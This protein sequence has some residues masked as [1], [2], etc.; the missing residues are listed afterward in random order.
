M[1][2]RSDADR[3]TDRLVCCVGHVRTGGESVVQHTPD[4]ARCTR[5]NPGLDDADTKQDRKGFARETQPGPGR[6]RSDTPDAKQL[7]RADGPPCGVSLT[8]ETS[9]TPH[10]RRIGKGRDRLLD[11]GGQSDPDRDKIRK[12]IDKGR[13]RWEVGGQRRN[14]G[15][16]IVSR[17]KRT[18]RRDT[19]NDL[20]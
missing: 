19:R 17:T 13:A 2:L 1:H 15:G 12:R 18:E 8:D 11:S 14:V 16:R 4:G 9:G 3:E 7:I 5:P 6:P 20:V 10:T